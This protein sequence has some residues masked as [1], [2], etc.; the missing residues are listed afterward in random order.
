[1]GILIRNALVLTQNE[2][3]EVLKDCDV[4]IE[5]NRIAKVGKGMREK[6]EHVLDG[7]GKLV[8]PGLVNTHTHLAMTL[9]R[10]Y[11]DDMRLE[12][13]LEKKIWPREAKLKPADVRAGS[14]LGCLEMIRGGTTS[15][16]DMYFMMGE[17][18][19]AVEKCGLRANLAHGMI[20]MDKPER[21]KKELAAGEAFVREW[22]GK[23]RGR[24]MASF[25]PHAIYTCSRELLEKTNELAHKHDVKI[26]IHLSESRKEVVDC[27]AKH[28]KRPAD[29]LESFGF[30]SKRVIAA[31]CVWL[32][33]EECALLG[34]RGVSASHVPASNMKL[35]GGGAMPIP[36]LEQ[37][38]ANICLGTDG[39]AS[40][41]S[42]SM[43][44]AMKLCALLHKNSRWD[45]T[46]APAQ[47][48]LDFAT[49]NGARAMGAE[50][51]AIAEGRLADLIMLDLRSPNLVPMHSAVSNV[52]Y[53][54][55]AGNVTD[56]I[57]DGKILMR[58]RKVV[59]FDE[60]KVMEAG[61]KAAFD[62]VSR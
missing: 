23:V 6:A 5:A 38:K 51:G 52:V 59:A 46:V 13:W 29:Y 17:T 41:N 62:L 24:I 58:E 10:G 20:D 11:A 1:M 35:A 61:E 3:R 40:N 50:A 2:R 14:M 22:N 31:H 28:S 4:L 18:A 27:L 32:R 12:D 7:R 26:H 44:G 54:A 16:V 21:R 43:F 39:A 36:E 49:R 15:F 30:L 34:K 25:G 56:V 47:Q 55:S 42:L 60:E 9:L 57:V 19:A 33:R 45:A 37:A 53:A 8:M 48:V